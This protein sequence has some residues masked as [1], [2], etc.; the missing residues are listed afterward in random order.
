MAVGNFVVG[1]SRVEKA[2]ITAR[3]AGYRVTLVGLRHKS[4]Q[5]V[6]FVDGDIPIMRLKLLYTHFK[7]V[8][9]VAA[10]SKEKAAQHNE[11]I[12]KSRGVVKRSKKLL[13]NIDRRYERW[14]IDRRAARGESATEIWP[15]LLDYETLFLDAFRFLEPDLIHVHDR[16][17]MLGADAYCRERIE[18]DPNSAVRW[19]YDAHEFLPGQKIPLPIENHRGWVYAE[20][21]LIHEADSVITVSEQLAKQLQRHHGL[22]ELPGVVPNS[23]TSEPQQ[24]KLPFRTDVRTDSGVPAEAKLAVYVGSIA[25]QRG[26]T[27]AVESLVYAKDFHVTVLAGS[28]TDPVRDSLRKQAARLGV[29]DRFHILDYVEPNAV[30]AY[31][32]T[33]DVGLSPL[34]PTKSHHTAAPTKVREYLHAGLPVVVSDMRAQSE[35]VRS[36]GVGLVFPNGNSRELAKAM[37]QAW[38][39]REQYRAASSLELRTDNSWESSEPVLL[40][41]WARLLDHVQLSPSPREHRTKRVVLLEDRNSQNSNEWSR[42]IFDLLRSSGVPFSE[43]LPFITDIESDPTDLNFMLSDS[44][45]RFLE[46]WRTEVSGISAVFYDG[47]MGLVEGWSTELVSG[48]LNM[49]GIPTFRLKP[50]LWG[51]NVSTIASR[52]PQHWIHDLGEEERAELSEQGATERREASRDFRLLLTDEPLTTLNTGSMARYIPTPTSPS[53]QDDK[54]ATAKIAIIDDLKRSDL[55]IAAIDKL[56]Q[57]PSLAQYIEHVS[58]Q[59]V[60]QSSGEYSVIVDSLSTDLPSS[61]SLSNVASGSRVITGAPDHDAPSRVPHALDSLTDGEFWISC[62]LDD[63]I[64]VVARERQNAISGSTDTNPGSRFVEREASNEAVLHKLLSW[65]GVDVSPH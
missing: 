42:G 5:Q 10:K 14:Q 16:H 61:A 15:Q 35:F 65:A 13:S 24:S 9:D 43:E 27:T 6:S 33:A 48:L 18:A 8:K 53:V 30:S 51:M 37:G 31:L 54:P 1:D 50:G 58:L 36:T 23:P 47:E 49:A 25:A 19:V 22:K 45:S 52:Y 40:D 55:E 20:R 2:A 60:L 32:A 56:Q 3:N 59:H 41:H 4:V 62:P 57:E 63:L 17:P 38:S 12:N 34:L 64:P 46:F 7:S 29:A 11:W 28:N 39:N 44:G 21:D 26:V